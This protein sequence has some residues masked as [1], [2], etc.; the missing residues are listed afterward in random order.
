MLL[1]FRDFTRLLA[2]R[3]QETIWLHLGNPA[4][5]I[6]FTQVQVGGDDVVHTEKRLFNYK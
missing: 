5:A 3:R 6:D 2:L 4:D 1:R